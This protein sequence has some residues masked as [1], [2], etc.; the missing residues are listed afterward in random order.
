MESSS[1]KDGKFEL[2]V[3][4]W[5]RLGGP[6]PETGTPCTTVTTDPAL[7]PDTCTWGRMEITLPIGCGV[8]VRP[9]ARRTVEPS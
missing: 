9:K 5:P 2:I 8:I 4:R 7:I 3:C 1:I 6:C